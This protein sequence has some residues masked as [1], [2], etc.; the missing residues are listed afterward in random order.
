MSFSFTPGMGPRGA[1]DQFGREGQD[2]Q[3]FNKNVL[4]GMLVFVRPYK[5]RMLLAII[6]MLV[7]TVFT[8]ITP[9][10]LKQ[11]IDEHIA[12][13][14][15]VGLTRLVALI[16]VCYLGLYI[17]TVA[18][19][20]L[21][22]WTSQR[23][24]SDVRE[25]MFRHLQELSLSYHDR[26]IIGVTVSRVIN[27]VAV[28]N[29]LLTQGL[30]S[31]LGDVLVLIGIIVIMLSM[32]AKLALLTFTVLPLMALATVWFSRSAKQ[33]FRQTRK[34]VAVLVGNLAENINGI[35]VIQAFAQ[36]TAVSNQFEAVNKANREAHIDA[37][38]LSFIFL[39]SIEFL[40]MLAT[41]IVLY[42]GGRA[43]AADEVTLGVMVAF[44]AYV[45]RFFQPIQELSRIYTTMQ[46]AMAGGEQVL[47]LLDSVP[48]VADAPDARLMPP[49]A[50]EVRLDQVSFRYKADGPDILQEVSLHIPAGQT[51]ALVG[52]TGAGKTTIANLVARFYDVTAG[53]V[54]IDG[55]D[56]RTVTQQSLHA[57]FGLVPQDPFLFAGTIADNIRYGRQDAPLA[58]VVEAAKLA[59]A[60]N[61]I[62]ALPDGYDTKILEGAVNLSVGQ[63]QLLCIARAALV[64]PR[65]LILD[66]AT[67]SVDT[68]TEVMIQKALDRLMA[69]RTAIVIAHRL[70]TIRH[71]DMICVVQ[72][73]RIVE[74][75]Q[76]EELMSRGGLYQQLYK[77][78]SPYSATALG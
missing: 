70:S 66:E 43:V 33:A 49:I 45:T 51:V 21:L 61:F 42:F 5:K 15:M 37:M 30:I 9:Y 57:Q 4:A 19:E 17:A 36:E 22:G 26:T 75:G 23:V 71:A 11:A 25:K 1:I 68:V 74:Q 67:A 20:Y 28:I 35:R 13:G 63:R 72:N 2:G 55:V 60:H 24:L 78:P 69:G 46:S 73:G 48:E 58:L 76:H 52:P 65:I 18:Q 40:G 56:V 64:E 3:A 50:G 10:L 54:L 77:N 31:L 34:Q 6:S 47:K 53:A 32:N 41:G 44:L 7:V 62:E 38:R 29:D 39:P 14:N 16:A 27:D 59:N 12:V 8:L